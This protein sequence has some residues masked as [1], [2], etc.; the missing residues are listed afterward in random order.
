M[1][2]H[3]A[4]AALLALGAA[5]QLPHGPQIRPSTYAPAVHKPLTALR[6]AVADPPALAEVP[7]GEGD[8][9]VRHPRVRFEK[10]RARRRSSFFF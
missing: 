8:P 1:R 5:F 2:G 10:L 4:A 7:G 3:V 9:L 6:S